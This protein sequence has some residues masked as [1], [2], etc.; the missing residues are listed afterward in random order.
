MAIR[1]IGRAV[2]EIIRPDG[3]KLLNLGTS[4]VGIGEGLAERVT[5]LNPA[6]SI[7]PIIKG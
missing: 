2:A 6:R 1:D 3:G 5:G 7:D 4:S